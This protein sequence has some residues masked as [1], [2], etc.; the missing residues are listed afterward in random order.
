MEVKKVEREI[1]AFIRR[2][3]A[4]LTRLAGRQSQLLE[5]AATVGVAEHYKAAGFSVEIHNPKS[6]RGFVVKSGTRGHPADY[7]RIHCSRNDVA[8]ELHMNALVRGGHDEGIYCVDVAI[9]VPECMP[10]ENRKGS[11]R[12]VCLPNNML[13]SFA[14]AKRLVVY[15]MLLAQFIGIVHEITPQFLRRARRPDFG[16][17]GHLPPTL[18][19][20]GNFSGNSVAIKRSFAKRR[21]A[22]VIAENY[23]IRLSVSRR[24]GESR[25][26]FYI[27]ANDQLVVAAAGPGTSHNMP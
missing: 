8:V 2:H 7:S 5:L 27:D 13:V 3:E 14:E 17:R 25:S 10:R 11:P 22:V 20:L 4:T 6:K 15:P 24:S 16:P 1:R 26:P 23:D 9:A 21:F 18:I 12:W 19:S